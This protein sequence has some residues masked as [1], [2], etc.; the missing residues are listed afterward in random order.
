MNQTNEFIVTKEYR[1]FVEFCNACKKDNYIGLCYGPAGVGKS[2]AAYNF[3]RWHEIEK[4][5]ELT[6]NMRKKPTIEIHG[7]DTII[8]VPSV[9]NSPK[10]VGDS[11]E[12]TIINFKLLHVEASRNNDSDSDDN[13]QEKLNNY[14]KLIIVDEAD[15][16]NPK[17]LEQVR[18]IYD[19][20]SISIILIGM[21]GIEK[22]LVRSPQLYSRVGFSHIYKP[23]SKEEIVFIVQNHLKALNASVD[24]ETF[25]DQEAIATFSLIT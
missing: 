21:P 1:R 12:N 25:S 14:V 15:R 20:Q 7:C 24:L 16:L 2:M 6:R 8:Y 23:L 9:S 22:R 3:A 19:R 10:A 18:D 11:I 4:E 13:W 5:M 17:G